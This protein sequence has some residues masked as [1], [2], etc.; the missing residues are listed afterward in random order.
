MSPK[1]KMA[2]LTLRGGNDVLVL[3]PRDLWSKTVIRTIFL[4]EVAREDS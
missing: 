3:T 1:K 2:L 4:E